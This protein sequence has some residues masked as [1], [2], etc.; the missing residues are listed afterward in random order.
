MPSTDVGRQGRDA[1]EVGRRRAMDV[2]AVQNRIDEIVW[3][4]EFDFGNGLRTRTYRPGHPDDDAYR[5]AGWA[6]IERQLEQEDLAGKS[7]LDIGCWDGYWSFYAERRGARPVLATDDVTQNWAGRTGVHLAKEL[8]G[9][10]IEIDLRRSVYDL[11]ALGRTFDR[12]FFFGVYYH[13]HSVFHA[14]AQIRHCCHPQTVVLVEGPITHG[15][16]DGAALYSFADHS[17]EWLPTIGALGQIA[18][19]TYFDLRAPVFGSPPEAVEAARR[20]E[21]ARGWRERL[22]LSADALRGRI[23]PPPGPRQTVNRVFFR[24]VPRTG[25]CEVH[26]YPPPFGL[27]TFDPRFGSDVKDPRVGSR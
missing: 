19:A 13:L 2:E 15:L 11:R 22:R 21:R 10:S 12:I 9:S 25:P 8:L 26:E 23:A 3:Y 20:E 18:D 24:L 27:A 17:C 16:P 1:R 6:F 14:L 4:H 5:R 7:V